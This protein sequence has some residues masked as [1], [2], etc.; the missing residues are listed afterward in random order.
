MQKIEKR[1]TA[2]FRS[3]GRNAWRLPPVDVRDEGRA[4]ED[5]RR[6]QHAGDRRVEV[7]QQLLETEEV[8]GR[9]G[10]GRRDAAV[11]ELLERGVDEHAHQE[12]ED[13]HHPGGEEL[14][15]QQ[16]RPGHDRVVRFLLD[17]HD[18]VLLDERKQ[19]VR[20]R[21]HRDALLVDLGPPG[22]IDR[23]ND[24]RFLGCLVSVMDVGTLNAPSS[25][26][27]R[28][29]RRAPRCHRPE[30]GVVAHSGPEIPP[31]FRIRQKWTARKTAMI[32]GMNMMWST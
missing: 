28:S 30:A 4:D 19:A 3:D 27:H 7:G 15:R 14:D 11:G 25:I 24:P 23:Q 20:S 13:R 21:R 12:Q 9:L 5:E 8:P 2:V 29:P 6:G 18:G 32:S 10:D 26:A 31:S 1:T 16:V 22:R 17:P